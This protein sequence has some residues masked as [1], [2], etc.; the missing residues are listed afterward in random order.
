MAEIK[1]LQEEMAKIATQ[2][3]AKLDEVTDDTPEDRAAEIE[4][5][6]DAMMADHDKLQA[7]AERLNKVEAALRA[8]EQVDFDRRPSFE[9]R[10]APVVDEG[11][12]MDYR[13]AFAEMIVNCGE[14]NVSPEARNALMEHRVQTGGSN[15]GGGFTVPTELANFIVESMK[16]FGPMYDDTMF[17]V[18]NDSSGNNFDIPTIDDTS[19]TAEPYTEGSTGTDDGG[20][21]A[22]F[23]KKTL[24]AY[25]FDTEWVR[26]SRALQMDSVLALESF[27]GNLLGKRLG[28]KANAELTNGSGVSAVQGI[29]TGSTAGHT[30]AS[31]TAIA[32]DELIDLVHSVDP[33]YRGGRVAFMMNDQ[34]LKAVRKLK[35]GNGNYLWQMGNF[36]NNIPQSL[37]GYSVVVNQD[38]ADIA[39]GN[40][41]ILFGDMSQYYV[42]KV[43]QPVIIPARERFAPS[44]GLIGYIR[45]DGLLADTAAV[46][47]LIQA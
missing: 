21:D 47:H 29:V 9:N 44:Y 12:K 43:G 25:E 33:A 37:L 23:G 31:A 35:D 20:K 1:Q 2:A 28:R 8:G 4:R 13:T 26:Y 15:T 24:S 41:T 16:A 38:M 7:K 5:E 46:K 11:A 3:R 36:Q 45:F 40:K 6:F 14:A 17:T 18:I 22:T 42:R 19:V 27:I 30:A 39:T 34:T 32:S 10:S